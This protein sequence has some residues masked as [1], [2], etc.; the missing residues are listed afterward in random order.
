[1]DFDKFGKQLKSNPRKTL[2]F[3]AGFVLIL[4]V[5]WVLVL[6]QADSLKEEKYVEIPGNSE[7][8]IFQQDE[9]SDE[10]ARAGKLT[11]I[12][13]ADNTGTGTGSMTAFLILLLGGS[14]VWIYL[15]KR[16][17]DG[18]EASTESTAGFKILSSEQV[19][20]TNALVL[21]EV[22]GEYWML[23]S[24]NEGLKILKAYSK[25]E[26]AARQDPPKPEKNNGKVFS[27]LLNGYRHNGNA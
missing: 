6:F 23:S 5:L 27:E 17:K 18:K 15:A 4:L 24:G 21:A 26:W 10:P 8:T 11:G 2:Q 20:D 25:G 13:E 14:G 12:R 16:N 22:N 19:S 3:V 7:M 9:K 1:M